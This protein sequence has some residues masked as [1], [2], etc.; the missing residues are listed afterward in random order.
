V[1]LSLPYKCGMYYIKTGDE[2]QKS[3]HKETPIIKY[4]QESGLRIHPD[5]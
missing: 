3:R 5:W 2:V 4:L 1:E